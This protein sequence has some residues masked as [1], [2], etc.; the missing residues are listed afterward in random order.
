MSLRIKQNIS[1][2]NRDNVNIF[3]VD[4]CMRHT[5]IYLRDRMKVII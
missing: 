1:V 4:I 2:E 5:Y 3:I